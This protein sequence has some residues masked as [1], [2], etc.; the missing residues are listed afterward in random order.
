ML[1]GVA[2]TCRKLPRLDSTYTLLGQEEAGDVVARRIIRKPDLYI[3]KV[4]K[5]NYTP[6]RLKLGA[7]ERDNECTAR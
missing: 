2:E 1:S 3:T 4:I 7:T 5:M 6:S